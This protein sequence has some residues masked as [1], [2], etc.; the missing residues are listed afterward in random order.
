MRKEYIMSEDDKREKR[1]KIEQNRAIKKRTAEEFSDDSSESSSKHM[2]CDRSSEEEGEEGKKEKKFSPIKLNLLNMASTSRKTYQ[3]KQIRY[4]GTG[5]DQMLSFPSPAVPEPSSPGGGADMESRTCNVFDESVQEFDST[6]S[7]S[8]EIYEISRVTER[9]EEPPSYDK[10]RADSSI[11]KTIL[12]AELPRSGYDSQDD[13]DQSKSD[14][15]DVLFDEAKLIELARNNKHLVLET[16]KDG[17]KILLITKEALSGNDRSSK[18][19]ESDSYSVDRSSNHDRE[20]SMPLLSSLISG[21]TNESSSNGLNFRRNV[22][23]EVLQDIPRY[24]MHCVCFQVVYV[25]HS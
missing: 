7:R 19:S 16:T 10:D 1:K 2:K 13:K 4:N 23:E 18:S 9:R 6:R 25:A 20:T 5:M 11:I 21:D 14:G 22:A 24:V 3:K 8:L 17:S 15:T 12:N